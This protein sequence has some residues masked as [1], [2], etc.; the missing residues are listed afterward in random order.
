MFLVPLA[1]F[2]RK[3]PR[4]RRRFLNLSYGALTRP[5][6]VAKVLSFLTTYRGLHVKVGDPID[7]PAFAAHAARTRGRRAS[8]A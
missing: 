2:W 1:L 5:N 3:G 4:A 8:R 7:L 6:D